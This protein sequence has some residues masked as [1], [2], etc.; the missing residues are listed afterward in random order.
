LNCRVWTLRVPLLRLYENRWNSLKNSLRKMS[1]PFGLIWLFE[2]RRVSHGKTTIFLE[3]ASS[4]TEI[5][6]WTVRNGTSF[7]SKDGFVA[8]VKDAI[9]TIRVGACN[10]YLFVY[11]YK[12]SAYSLAKQTQPYKTRRAESGALRK[13]CCVSRKSGGG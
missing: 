12:F 7:S 13:K 3:G 5:P 4:K 9:V 6:V 2:S 8:R 11:N 1:S 10:K